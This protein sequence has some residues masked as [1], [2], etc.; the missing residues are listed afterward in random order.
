MPRLNDLRENKESFSGINAGAPSTIDL[1]LD[2]GILHE[3]VYE[4]A[5]GG[6]LASEAVMLAALDRVELLIDGQTYS[7]YSVANIFMLDKFYGETVT[8][9]FLPLRFAQYSRKSVEE[10]ER[11]SFVPAA[12]NKPSMRL[13]IN[14]GRVAP[15]LKQWLTTEGLGDTGR[16]LVDQSPISAAQQTIKHYTDIIDINGSGNVPTKERYVHGGDRIRG[17]HLTGS[18]ITKVVINWNEQERWVF[19][20]LAHLNRKL[21]SN[22]YVP[23]ADT[24]H[25]VFEALAG[26]SAE[27]AL[28]PLFGGVSNKIDLEIY[29]SDTNDVDLLVERYSIP[30]VLPS[31]S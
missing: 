30:R 5:E 4:Y 22:G 8:A 2:R 31:R 27:A 1:P 19:E 6:T 15:T 14:G 12:H 29:T 13:Y 3:A 11:T 28:D 10:A 16:A 7:E 21:I 18:N 20:S 26:G 17:F 23:Q 24:W 25:I 9:G